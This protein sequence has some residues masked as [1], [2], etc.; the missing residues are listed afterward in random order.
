MT[1]P[2]VM[3]VTKNLCINGYNSNIGMT[4][5]MTLA[6]LNVLREDRASISSG[7]MEL[8]AIIVALAASNVCI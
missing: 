1:E 7:V 4:E 3:P 6:A 2:N 8:D 5:I